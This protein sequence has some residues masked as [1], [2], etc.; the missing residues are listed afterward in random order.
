MEMT[1]YE[2]IYI[3]FL[4]S[5]RARGILHVHYLLR[6]NVQSAFCTSKH[7]GML[8][9]ARWRLCSTWNLLIRAI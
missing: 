4:I 9:R 5:D 2:P 6:L 7:Q 1:K 8:E 3:N